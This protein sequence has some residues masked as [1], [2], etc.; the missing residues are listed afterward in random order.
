MEIWLLL[1]RSPRG[2]KRQIF[3]ST[4]P[5]CSWDRKN[6][7]M[8]HACSWV[9]VENLRA[10][11]SGNHEPVLS[12]GTASPATAIVQP[13]WRPG[14]IVHTWYGTNLIIIYDTGTSRLIIKGRSVKLLWEIIEL[15]VKFVWP[16]PIYIIHITHKDHRY[17][18]Y[19]YSLQENSKPA[20]A[21]S[22]CN[23]TWAWAL[24]NLK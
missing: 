17:M 6:S 11:A 18:Y 22:R 20:T 5:K 19:N 13:V 2:D 3:R 1:S 14:R 16:L 21:E 24:S 7:Q 9:R 15:S 4:T 8:V 12:E 10:F 23:Y